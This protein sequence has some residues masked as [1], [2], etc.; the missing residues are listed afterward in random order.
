MQVAR[1]E[2][3]LI[4]GFQTQYIPEGIAVLSDCNVWCI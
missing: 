3:E 1:I 2:L 4:L